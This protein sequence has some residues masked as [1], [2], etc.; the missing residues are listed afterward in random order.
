M[1]D[2]IL[3]S[4]KNNIKN[5]NFIEGR[6]SEVSGGILAVVKKKE[7]LK[8]IDQLENIFKVVGKIKKREKEC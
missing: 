5:F 7:F 8:N 6:C 4:N 3:E 2:G 1:I